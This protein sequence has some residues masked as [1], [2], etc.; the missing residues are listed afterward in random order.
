MKRILYLCATIFCF[1]VLSCNHSKSSN[2]DIDNQDSIEMLN[3][4]ETE[5]DLEIAS[6]ETYSFVPILRDM[7]SAEA[8]LIG[9]A[10]LNQTTGEYLMFDN[11]ANYN[12]LQRDLI[13]IYYVLRHTTRFYTS[14]HPVDK[15]ISAFNNTNEAVRLYLNGQKSEIKDKDLFQDLDESYYNHSMG[16]ESFY[17]EH[18]N[19]NEKF[20]AGYTSDGR[21]CVLDIKPFNSEDDIPKGAP[22]IPQGAVMVII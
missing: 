21:R 1:S 15:I 17:E 12:Y 2:Q 10:L 6:E 8:K 11:D 5:V 9:V 3:A 14:Y 18:S 22:I 16:I 13:Q 20:H 7:G 19:Y 4:E